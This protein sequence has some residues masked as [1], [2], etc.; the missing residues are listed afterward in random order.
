MEI[1]HYCGSQLRR[2]LVATSNRMIGGKKINGI[3]F[4][5]VLDDDAPS[6]ELRQRLIDVTFLKT[7]GLTGGGGALA[8]TTACFSI[9]GGV[10]ITGLKV[11]KIE[12]GPTAASVRLTLDRYGD[13]SRYRLV[14]TDGV[15][16]APPANFDH[17]LASVEFSFKADCPTDFDCLPAQPGPDAAPG[18]AGADYLAKDY[19][20]FRR[21]MLDRMATTIPE[22]KERSPADL[23]VTLVEALA[24]AADHASYYQDAIAAEAY[25]T[26]ARERAS[27]RR[28]ARL[29]GYA[30]NEGCNARCFVAFEVNTDKESVSPPAL[31]AGTMLLTPPSVEAGFGDLDPALPPDPAKITALLRAGVVVF[32]T[33]E[34]LARLLTARNGLSFHNW[35]GDNCCLPKGSTSAF[36]VASLAA[37]KLAKGD[38][39][40]L[41]E[42]IPIGGKPGDPPDPTHRR[43][44]RLIGTPRE[45]EDR[46]DGSVVLEI[47]WGQEDAL[48]FA[49]N[50]EPN[51]A[52]ARG[53]VVLADHGR[54]LD[55]AYANRV[56]PAIAAQSLHGDLVRRSALEP[57]VAPETGRYRPRV[58]DQPLTRA[59]PY[60]PVA[61]RGLS[62]RATLAQEAGA[63]LPAIQLEGD[64]ESWLPRAD[65]L[66]SDRF[67]PEFVVEADN[68]GGASL[69][70]GDGRFGRPVTP[71]AAMAARIRIGVGAAGNIGADALGHV[72]TDDPAIFD[73]VRNPLPAT[74]GIEAET[75][76]A[77]KLFAPRSFKTQKRAV[78]SDDYAAAAQAHPDVQRATA[79]RRWTGSWHTQFIAVDRR[80]G[81][82]VD[83]SFEAELRAHLENYR[84]AG[85]DVE[86][87]PPAFVPLDI[88]LIVC[89][90]AGHYAEQ[91]EAALLDRFSAG[92]SVSGQPGYFHPDRFSF[93][94]AVAL[95]PIIAAAMAVE[96]VHWVG[97][98]IPGFAQKGR[99]RILTDRSVDYAADGAIPIG[100]RQIARLDNDANAPERG[101]LQ[102]LMEGGR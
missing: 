53:N 73:K 23:G 43:A 8:L 50:L 46:L 1:R 57:A 13:F 93:A 69:R 25:L 12:P 59:A 78:T 38:V 72:V 33:M 36:V 96:G 41:E 60:D 81:R 63:A 94:E 51:A 2:Q 65:L 56:A 75:L 84:L 79:E 44:V 19:E 97:M 67:A 10:R 82:P 101:R 80:G 89:V 90:A 28:H 58:T 64:G 48:D 85:H 17:A 42:R 16:D 21:L 74:G 95:S 20:S 61:A 34:P 70:F 100:R 37:T 9:E 91:V 62:A 66:F 4:L 49:L 24:Y 22:W 40:I 54:T 102:F 32:E 31:P 5:E 98:D 92:T 30:I 6:K 15:S 76:T 55:Y 39:L 83:R 26:R 87:E 3:D 29:L 99:F 88:A 47:V 14:F 52:V 71:G 86:I 68:Q 27:A 7:D 35:S 77:I 18:P 11:I 45:I